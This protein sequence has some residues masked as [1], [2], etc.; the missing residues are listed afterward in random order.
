METRT[1]GSVYGDATETT[2]TLPLRRNDLNVTV[3]MVLRAVHE[4]RLP[5]QDAPIELNATFLVESLFLGKVS[6]E[7]PQVVI[8]T[9]ES[10]TQIVFAGSVDEHA[11]LY[12][13]A[14]LSLPLGLDTLSQLSASSKII[15]RIFSVVFPLSTDQGRLI[16]EFS[17]RVRRNP[18]RTGGL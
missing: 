8:A 4:K 1:I 11:V 3:T 17:Q 14:G 16:G 9:G 12:N 2:L 15:T 13:V 7:R 5:L 6:F 10:G 18:N